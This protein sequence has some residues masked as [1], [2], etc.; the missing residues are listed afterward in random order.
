[1]HD[2][3]LEKTAIGGAALALVLCCCGTADAQQIRSCLDRAA[4]VSAAAAL[5][6]TIAD[7]DVYN[8]V[9][10]APGEQ[11]VVGG[12]W[13]VAADLG[14]PM[15]AGWNARLSASSTRFGV[16]QQTLEPPLSV[17]VQSRSKDD[18]LVLRRLTAGVL[19]HFGTT[20]RVCAYT[21][22]GVGWYQF[23]H[24]GVTGDAIG[25]AG[26]LGYEVPTGRS[27]AIVIEFQLDVTTRSTGPPLDNVYV[28][29]LGV[30][31][32]FRRRF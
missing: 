6:G 17:G 19:K 23:A 32:G 10:P 26:V 25:I 8:P 1:M 30:S 13:G 3:D 20:R 4:R 29:M 16:E 21:A 5:T 28:R 15:V 31:A 14:V 2:I 27:N 11:V 24:H 22:I 12:G 7:L 9:S 18:P